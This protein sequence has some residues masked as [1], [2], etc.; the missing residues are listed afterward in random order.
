MLALRVFAK[1]K[2]AAQRTAGLLAR[3]R[4]DGVHLRALP[5]GGWR[6]LAQL[7]ARLVADPASADEVGNARHYDRDRPYILFYVIPYSDGQARRRADQAFGPRAGLPAADVRLCH[8]PLPVDGRRPDLQARHGVHLGRRHHRR[9]LLRRRRTGRRDC[10]RA[11]AQCRSVR[12]D[13]GHHGYRASVRSHEELDSGSP[14][15]V[16]LQEALRLP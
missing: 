10:P 6:A 12:V 7:P 11:S 5:D 16:L 13:R 15:H 14:G 8:L 1:Q 9:R 3:Q 2:L 4:A